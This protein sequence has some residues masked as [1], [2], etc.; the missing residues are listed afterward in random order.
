MCVCL[1]V[2]ESMYIC[3]QWEGVCVSARVCVNVYEHM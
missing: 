2:S 1:L 3:V